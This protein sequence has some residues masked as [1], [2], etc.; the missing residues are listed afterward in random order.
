MEDLGRI[1][2]LIHAHRDGDDRAYDLAIELLYTELRGLAHRHI[3]RMG[4]NPTLQTTAVVS[5]AYLKLKRNGSSAEDSAHFL[6]IAAKAMRQII[7]DYARAKKAEKRGGDAIHVELNGDEQGLH[8][9]ID[10]VL[11]VNEALEK[12]AHHSERLA[13]VFELKFFTGLDDDEVAAAMGTSKRT[14]QRDWMKS[15]AFMGEYLAQ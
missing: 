3:R 4:G 14:A 1:T 12:L 9:E 7:V 10:Q 11:M 2:K 5:E 8:A 13:Q 15:R 6:N